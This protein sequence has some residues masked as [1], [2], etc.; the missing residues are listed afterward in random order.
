MNSNTPNELYH[1]SSKNNLIQNFYIIG[2]SLNDFFVVNQKEKTGEFIDIFKEKIEDIP[3][4]TPKIITKFPNIKNSINT[5]SDDL[6]VDHCFPN[7]YLKIFKNVKGEN[8]PNFYQFELDNI[9]QNYQNEEQKIYSK[10]YF[11]CLE[12]GESISEYFQYKKEII[13]QI[14]KYKSIKILNFDKNEPSGVDSKNKFS[15]FLIPKVLCFSSV[16][17]F[18]NEL[19]QLLK[20]IH[21]Y[22]LSKKDFASLPLEKVIEKIILSTPIPIKIGTELSINFKTSNYKEKISFPICNI[23]DININYSS[24]MC[25]AEIFRCFTSDDVIRIFRYILYEIPLLFFSENKSILSLFV[26][27]FLTVLSPFKYPFPHIAILPRKL[28]GLINSEKKFIFGINQNYNVDFFKTYNIELD[29]TIVVISIALPDNNK[30]N[31]KVIFDEKIFDNNNYDKFVIDRKS[32]KYRKEEFITFNNN[33]THIINID[34]PNVFKKKL[35]DGI[36]KYISFI[37]KK[38]L[39]SKKES[40]PKDLTFKIQNVFYKFF[41]RI[42]SGYTE[43]FLKSSNFYSEPKNIGEKMHSYHDNDILKEVFNKEE[44]YKSQKECTA[45]YYIFFDTKIFSNFFYERLYNNNIIDQ[46][47]FRQFDLLTFL[48][49]HSE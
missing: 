41:V 40:V 21:D 3:K 31:P 1:Q 48:K 27:T 5:I 12:I 10:I 43:Y 42:M 4:L 36:N 39:F 2:F 6:V 16:L 24:D 29:K 32:H 44:F 33:K 46:L 25:L 34:I 9:P 11:T 15:E 22:S 8:E 7:G 26:N 47:A 37:G 30:K 14:F 18:Y 17:P 38:K 23:N 28:Y 13:N 20:S 19:S 45:F 35:S 49:K